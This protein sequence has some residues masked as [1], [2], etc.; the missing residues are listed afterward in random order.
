MT[1]YGVNLKSYKKTEVTSSWKLLRQKWVEN[2]G[3]AEKFLRSHKRWSESFRDIEKRKF[4]C[5]VII[6]S[7]KMVLNGQLTAKQ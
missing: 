5:R 2:E 4:W 1:K 3:V 6:I 7:Q